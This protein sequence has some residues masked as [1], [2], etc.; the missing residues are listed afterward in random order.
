M[1][2]PI[3]AISSDESSKSKIA[4]L[5][6]MRSILVLSGSATPPHQHARS[7]AAKNI[8]LNA[9]LDAPGVPPAF[10]AA[11]VSVGGTAEFLS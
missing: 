8:V 11:E 6:P 3:V 4:A 9:Q 1:S 7:D 5:F 10:G 2:A